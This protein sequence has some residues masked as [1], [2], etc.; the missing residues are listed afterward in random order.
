ML[1]PR[2]TPALI[3]SA[4][5]ANGYLVPR[6]NGPVDPGTAPDF[7]LYDEALD[8][9][10]VV[11][12]STTATP[13]TTTTSGDGM[14]NTYARFYQPVSGDTCDKTVIKFRTFT[15]KDF[16]TWNPAVKDDYSG[17]WADITTL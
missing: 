15:L 1:F 7:R 17:L 12:S 13:G 6:Q 10:L 8:I 9:T 14:V 2:L 16:V 5:V 3:L 11:P 4:A